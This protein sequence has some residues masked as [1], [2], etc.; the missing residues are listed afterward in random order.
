MLYGNHWSFGED[1][2]RYH[3]REIGGESDRL[4]S[5]LQLVKGQIVIKH[6]WEEDFIL[7]NKIPVSTIKIPEWRFQAFHEVS[8]FE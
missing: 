8:L 4:G 5:K 6:S 1:Q 7:L 3:G 2:A